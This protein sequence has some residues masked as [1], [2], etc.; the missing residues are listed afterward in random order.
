MSEAP[1]KAGDRLRTERRVEPAV[2]AAFADLVDDHAEQHHEG[3]G[4]PVVAHGLL[5]AS[6][7]FAVTAPYGFIGTRVE[8]ESRTPA[9]AGS[10]LTTSVDVR[11]VARAAGLGWRVRL[12]FEVRDPRGRVVLRGT[13][14]GLI[15]GEPVAGHA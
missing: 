14:E 12:A 13:S 2:V 7:P 8:L 4:G 6:L 11:D 15:P 3:S 9:F 1:L 10:M 5:V